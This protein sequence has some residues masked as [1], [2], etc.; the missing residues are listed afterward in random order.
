MVVKYFRGGLFTN[1]WTACTDGWN[2]CTVC[3][4]WMEGLWQ[5]SFQ[6]NLQAG[7]SSMKWRGAG[8]S[9][10]IVYGLY[11]V[12]EFISI[13]KHCIKGLDALVVVQFLKLKAGL[14]N[15]FFA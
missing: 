7:G 8:F 12:K 5:V 10:R 1:G 2:G 6:H 4:S 11:E 3:T 15:L 14:L 9:Y 13:Y